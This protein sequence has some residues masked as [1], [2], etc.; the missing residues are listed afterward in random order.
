LEIY[1]N[2]C[3]KVDEEPVFSEGH[4]KNSAQSCWSSA[5]WNVYWARTLHRD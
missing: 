2:K 3:V 5:R 1:K 4:R